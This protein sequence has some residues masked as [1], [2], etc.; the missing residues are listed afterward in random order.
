MVVLFF[1]KFNKLDLVLKSRCLIADLGIQ[2]IFSKIHELSKLE[3]SEY[4]PDNKYPKQQGML[5]QS[6]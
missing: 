4:G 3:D 6:L 2:I 5:G 1:S